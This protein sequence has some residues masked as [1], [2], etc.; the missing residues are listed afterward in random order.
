MI[1]LLHQLH[2]DIIDEFVDPGKSLHNPCYVKFSVDCF[3]IFDESHLRHI[4]LTFSVA[5]VTLH[6]HMNKTYS[7]FYVYVMEE[8][9]RGYY[10]IR[11]S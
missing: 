4:F 7:V 2:F 8:H 9:F 3:L 11:V 1:G 5:S 6:G 10:E